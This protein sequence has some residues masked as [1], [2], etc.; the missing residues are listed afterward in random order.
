MNT[1]NKLYLCLK[2]ERPEIKVDESTRI[3]AVQPIEKMLEIS[4]KYGL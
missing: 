2:N 1:L 3:K 4:A